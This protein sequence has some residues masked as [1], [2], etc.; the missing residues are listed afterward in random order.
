MVID[1]LVD[2]VWLGCCRS[3]AL[4]WFDCEVVC[5]TFAPV[6]TCTVRLFLIAFMLYN[7]HVSSS[8]AVKL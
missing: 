7:S 4:S 1:P 5:G 3:V 6:I 2:M 8:V